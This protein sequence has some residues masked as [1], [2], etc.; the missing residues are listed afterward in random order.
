MWSDS[1]VNTTLLSPE[2]LSHFCICQGVGWS[3]RSQ[4]NIISWTFLCQLMES[5]LVKLDEPEWI[6]SNGIFLSVLMKTKM[7]IRDYLRSYQSPVILF[8]QVFFVLLCET[9]CRFLLWLTFVSSRKTDEFWTRCK[10]QA[11][12][13]NSQNIF[14]REEWMEN[15]VHHKKCMQIVNCRFLAAR[16]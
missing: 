9:L 2:S 15:K 11:T 6:E 4:L 3:F 10:V 8:L 13:N 12:Q 1:W 7:T 16:L 14:I 5:P